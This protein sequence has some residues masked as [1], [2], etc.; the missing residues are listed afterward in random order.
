MFLV[1][2]ISWWYGGGWKGQLQRIHDRLAAT[3]GYFSIGQLLST[4]FSPFR[5]ISAGRTTGPI[6]AQL[7]AFFDKTLSRGIGA[8]VRSFTILFG[9]IVM[10]IQSLTELIVLVIWLIL[11]TLPVLGIIM[12]AIGWVPSWM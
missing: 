12:F 7:R 5:Q 4:L 3:A 8:I 9:I 1:G 6:G 10:G 2:I 11:P